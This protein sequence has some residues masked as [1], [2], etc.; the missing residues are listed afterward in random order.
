MKQTLVV[1]LNWFQMSRN[2]TEGENQSITVNHLSKWRDSM[3]WRKKTERWKSFVGEKQIH[4]LFIPKL[5]FV[6]TT[7]IAISS[8]D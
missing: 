5:L 6:L 1:I 4:L 8:V 3:K 7:S 2:R